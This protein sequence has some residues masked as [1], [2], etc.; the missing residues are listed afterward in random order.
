MKI[1]LLLYIFAYTFCSTEIYNITFSEGVEINQRIK[2]KNGLYEITLKPISCDESNDFYLRLKFDDLNSAFFIKFKV[3]KTNNFNFK[4]VKAYGFTSYPSDEEL[5]NDISKPLVNVLNGEFSHDTK[6][7]YYTYGFLAQK[8]FKYASISI[9]IKNRNYDY[10][11]ITA[12]P[13]QN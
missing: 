7:E 9:Y 11:G 13:K 4:E 8:D 12:Y 10:I 2:E 6:Y 1:I 5:T 3:D